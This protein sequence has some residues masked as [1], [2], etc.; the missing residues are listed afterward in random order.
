MSEDKTKPRPVPPPSSDPDETH[1]GVKIRSGQDVN[2]GGDVAGRDVVK[3]TTNVGFSVDAVQ[4]LVIAV[5]LMVFLTAACFFSGGVA[6]GGVALAA[7]DR[8][9]GSSQAAADSMKAKLD[10]IRALGPGQAFQLTFSEDE[11]SSYLRFIAGPRMGLSD[12]KVRLLEPGKLVIGGQSSSLGSVPFAA[13]FELQYNT[14]GKPLRLTGAAIHILPLGNSGFGWIVVPTFL[15][16]PV[17]DQVNA[18]IGAGY[19]LSTMTD[20]SNGTELSWMVTGVTR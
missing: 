4:R 8:K 9:V 6:V 2:V 16:N 3:N 11:I 20:V 14:P 10:A 15:L 7:L 13:T 12:G 17:A 1:P 5:G 18:S 19:E